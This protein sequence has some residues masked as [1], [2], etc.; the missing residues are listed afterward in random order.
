MMRDK[1]QRLIVNRNERKRK[2]NKKSRGKWRR[3]Q[4]EIERSNPRKINTLPRVTHNIIK[5]SNTLNFI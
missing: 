2:S 4:C 5:D 1:E 3:V